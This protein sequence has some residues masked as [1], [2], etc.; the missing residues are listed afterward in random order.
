MDTLRIALHEVLV[1]V[2]RRGAARSE[3]GVRRV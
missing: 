1:V 2:A 3:V